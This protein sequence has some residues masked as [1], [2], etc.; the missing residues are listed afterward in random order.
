MTFS[1]LENQIMT[2]CGLGMMCVFL[3]V[4]YSLNRLLESEFYIF[5]LFFILNFIFI[6]TIICHTFHRKSICDVWWETLARICVFWLML[7]VHLLT[8]KCFSLILF[9]FECLIFRFFSIFRAYAMYISWFTP[10]KLKKT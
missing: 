2:R 4:Y 1:I 9:L 5:D 8:V 3:L 10:N 7:F 6:Q